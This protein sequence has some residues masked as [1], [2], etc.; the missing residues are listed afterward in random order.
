MSYSDEAKKSGAQPFNWIELHLER[1]NLRWGTTNANGTCPAAFG[2]AVTDKCVNSWATCDAPSSFSPTTHI[3][4]FSEAVDN[5]PLNEG[6]IPFLRDINVSPGETDPGNSIGKR[7]KVTFRLGDAPHDDVGID[8]YVE[9]R[10]DGT[11]NVSGNSFDPVEQGTF[12]PRFRR[13]WPHYLGRKLVWYEGWLP[14]EPT[15]LD[16]D[17]FNKREYIIESLKGPGSDGEV[18]IVAK[19]PLKKADRERAKCPFPTAGELVSDMTDSETPTEIDVTIA[20]AT[21]YDLKAGE[22]EDYVAIG[23]EVFTYTGTT[24]ITDGVRLT[25]VT[26]SPPDP[27]TTEQESHDEGDRVQ[28]CR[29]LQGR[30]IDVFQELLEDFAGLPSAYIPFTEWETEHT[31]FLAGLTVQRLVVEPEGVNDLL[32]E[33]IGQSMTWSLWWR[34]TEQTIGYRALRPPDTDDVVDTLT[35]DDHLVADSIDVVDE[36][37]RLINQVHALYGQR[38]PTQNKDEIGNYRLGLIEID[39]D[40]QSARE[41]NE[42]RE[43]VI[44]A[45]WHPPSNKSQV[46]RI[47]RRLL[48]SRVRNLQSIEFEVTK[49]D[50]LKTAEF[51]NLN[52]IWLRDALGAPRD[53]RVQIMR[54][55][56]DGDTNR[57]TAREDS[58][59]GR[60]GRWAP[61]ALNG[62][63]W[64]NA[65]EEQREQYLFW[66]DA[67]GNMSDGS[68]GYRWL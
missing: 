32:D 44:F 38:D 53:V 30:P 34:E 61:A 16:S 48:A 29:L 23:D 59:L 20:D 4:K 43:H 50:D 35:D 42:E 39:D 60:Y 47:S 15:A 28:R 2:G 18:T 36:P 67:S 65:T 66:S 17:N 9:D 45:R 56:N 13:R 11:A 14:H 1:C 10:K 24:A 68:T 49:K 62:L 46:A 31:T 3:F 54:V 64:A 33:L 37:E 52:T 8:H 51:C 7:I 5:L 19:D 6:F 57:Y 63:T 55:S 25:G 41:V 12:W 40:S 22:T 26:R 27:Y 58:F 21:A